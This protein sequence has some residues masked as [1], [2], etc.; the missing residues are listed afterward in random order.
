MGMRNWHFSTNIS[1]YFENGTRYGHSYNGKQREDTDTWMCPF[2][3]YSASNNSV[4]LKS[5]FK[6]TENGAIQ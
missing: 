1:L 4:T 5:G 3:R 2:L 6:V